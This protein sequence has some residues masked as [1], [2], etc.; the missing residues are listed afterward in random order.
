MIQIGSIPPDDMANQW[1]YQLDQ[2]VQNYQTELSALAWGLRLEWDNPEETLGIDLSPHPHFVCCQRE[3]IEKLNNQ[4]NNQIQE[5]LGVLDGYNPEEEVVMIAIGEG[6][7]KLINFQSD[8]SPP[9][10]LAQS[11]RDL[12]ALIQHLETELLRLFP[13]S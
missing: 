12:D 5:I 3:A 7:L 10:C 8:P 9:E 1:R 13:S 6:Q 2:F 4:V 11:D